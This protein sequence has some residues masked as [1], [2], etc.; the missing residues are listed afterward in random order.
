MSTRWDYASNRAQNPLLLTLRSVTICAHAHHRLRMW[1]RS[2]TEYSRSI[3][4]GRMVW[5]AFCAES[6]AG[7][8]RRAGC[9]TDGLVLRA[10]AVPR[11]CRVRAAAGHPVDEGEAR[12]GLSGA[13]PGLHHADAAGNGQARP[14]AVGFAAAVPA[15]SRLRAG[16][17]S[18][19]AWKIWWGT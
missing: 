1:A 14:A 5:A 17:R 15:A 7:R 16:A 8:A 18:R 13:A 3:A 2:V 19:S 12:L 9:L 6:V 11:G 4:Q 10:R